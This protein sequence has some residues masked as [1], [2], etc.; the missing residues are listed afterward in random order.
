VHKQRKKER[1]SSTDLPITV[2]P[3]GG[4]AAFVDRD[5]AEPDDATL[6][7]IDAGLR[8]RMQDARVR[9]RAY[10]REHGEDIPEVADCTWTTGPERQAREVNTGV[11]QVN[12]GAAATGGGNES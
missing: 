7:A 9:A 3:D 5:L 11:G 12:P 2:T 6:A 8:Q 1:V 10:T 4:V